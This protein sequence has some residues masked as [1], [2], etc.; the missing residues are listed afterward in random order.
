MFNFE[1]LHFQVSFLSRCFLIVVCTEK[2]AVVKE[3]LYKITY[4]ENVPC[5]TKEPGCIH[6]VL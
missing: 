3:T 1:S 4:H 6:S 5:L 2:V